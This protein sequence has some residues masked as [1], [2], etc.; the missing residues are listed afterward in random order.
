MT[1]RSSAELGCGPRGCLNLLSAR[2]G[3]SSSVT[4]VDISADA[5]ARAQA[6]AAGH[7][8]SNVNVM[9][10]DAGSTGL[11]AAAF[12]LVT[13]R[14]LLVNIPAPA[15][16]VSEAVRLARPG[17]AVAFHEV[18]WGAVICD[19]PS[20]AW[21]ELTGLYVKVTEE[22]GIDCYIRRKLPRMLSDSPTACCPRKA[23]PP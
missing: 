23:L 14:L 3:Q 7:G 2:V 12:D 16:V 19:P 20:T 10:A 1:T 18:D 13:S 6:F 5:V 9:R 17:G 15:R 8:L 22:N 11:P 4:G 21:T